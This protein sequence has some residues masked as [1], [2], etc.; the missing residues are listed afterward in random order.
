MA[1][2]PV[3]CELVGEEGDDAHQ[4]VA[5]GAGHRIDFIHLPDYFSPTYGTAKSS[6]MP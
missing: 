4:D 5:L 3:H 2:D 6:S 1:D